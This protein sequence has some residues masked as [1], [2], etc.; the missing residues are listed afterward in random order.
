M[1]YSTYL[2]GSAGGGTMT[3]AIALDSSNNAYVTGQATGNFPTTPGAFQKTGGGAFVTKFAPTGSTV[4]ST[5]LGVS[6][7]DSGCGIA[8]DSSGNAYV[9]GGAV[10]DFPVTA[11]AFQTSCGNP[12]TCAFVTKNDPVPSTTTKLKSSPNPSSYGQ[13]VTLNAG[14]TSKAGTP[15]DGEI[16]TFMDGSTE[17]GTGTLTGGSAS[18]ATSA[19]PV[20]K[21]TVTAVYGGDANFAGSKSNAVKQV[22]KKAGE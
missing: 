15:R 22:V 9:T 14:V 12:N 17:L 6:G 20:G 2:G 18:Y 21:S 16:V 10:A 3:K 8:V 19:L 1:V 11:G 7:I 5:F 4:Y 13:A